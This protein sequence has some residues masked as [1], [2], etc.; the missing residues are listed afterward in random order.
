MA[1]PTRRIITCEEGERR[2]WIRKGRESGRG[3]GRE[4]RIERESK[5]E[6]DAVQEDLQN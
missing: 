4:K 3:R 5:G 2:E 1:T 6:K